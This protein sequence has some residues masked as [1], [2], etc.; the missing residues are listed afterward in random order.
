[1]D[2]D[3]ANGTNDVLKSGLST[4]TYGGTL[5]LVNLS[6]PLTNGSSFKLFSASSYLGSFAT[7][8]PA[9]PGAGQA[10]N[11]SAL[12]TTGTIKGDVR[13]TAKHL[14]A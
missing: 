6:S 10:W 5:N 12:N 4:I 2:L 7:I 1:M 8:T 9:T 13:R 14:A 3:P 11:I